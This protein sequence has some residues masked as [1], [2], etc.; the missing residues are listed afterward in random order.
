M[1][2]KAHWV[3]LAGI[4]FICLKY[5]SAQNACNSSPC[6]NGATCVESVL[7]PGYVCLCNGQFNGQQCEQSAFSTRC[8]SDSYT[9]SGT[10]TSPNY[11]SNYTQRLIC[12]YNIRVAN[13]SFLT[14]TFSHLEIERYKDY[15]EIAP[16]PFFIETRETDTNVPVNL[17][18]DGYYVPP[19]L[20]FT[21]ETNQVVILF[22]SD[23][24]VNLKGWSLSYES[25][26]SPCATN[27]CENGGSCLHLPPNGYQCFCSN[28]WQGVNCSIAIDPCVPNPCLNEATCDAISLTEYSCTCVLGW[29]GDLCDRGLV[30]ITDTDLVILSG[31]PVTEGTSQPL[32]TVNINLTPA[33]SSFQLTGTD[34]WRFEFYYSN[35]NDGSGSIIGSGSALLTPLQASTAWIPPNVASFNSV[36]V[37]TSLGVITCSEYRYLCV[38]VRK[39]TASS[40]DYDLVGFPDL[41]ALNHCADVGCR[42]VEITG[43]HLSLLTSEL[44]EGVSSQP[45]QFNLE[46]ESVAEA[47]S[48]RGSNLWKFTMFGS[49]SSNGFGSPRISS[50]TA[51]QTPGHRNT[52]VNAGILSVFNNLQGTF[53]LNQIICPQVPYFCVQVEKGDTAFPDFTFTGIPDESILTACVPVPCIGV[54]ITRTYFSIDAGGVFIERRLSHS[55]DFSSFFT[56]SLT[57]GSVSGNRLWEVQ[58]FASSS[59]DGSGQ[60]YSVSNVPLTEQQASVGNIAGSS[61]SLQQLTA[62][63]N[64]GG[65]K[66]DQL[67]YMCVTLDKGS[68]ASPNFT[69]DPLPNSEVLTSCTAIECNGVIVTTIIPRIIRGIPIQYGYSS[70]NFTCELTVNAKSD[71]ASIAGSGLWN[72]V[73]YVNNQE[74]GRGVRAAEQ[75]ISLTSAHTTT[76]LAAG[77]Q[78]FFSQLE[79]NFDLSGVSSCDDVMFLCFELQKA[80]SSIPDFTLEGS[81][82]TCLSIN[83]QEYNACDSNPC[84]NGGI[85]FKVG[86]AFTCT[87]AAGWTGPV[88]T[89]IIDNCNPNPCVNGGTCV[90]Q[91]ASYSC[92]CLFGWRGPNCGETDTGVEISGTTVL[93]ESGYLRQSSATNTF[94]LDV[95]L[96]AT[97]TSALASGSGLWKGRA[98]GSSSSSGSGVRYA[99]QDIT[100]DS[101]QAETSIVPNTVR[102]INNVMVDF[103]FSN[104]VCIE[105]QYLCVEIQKGDNP[106]PDFILTGVPSSDALVGCVEVTCLGVEITSIFSGLPR[107]F[108]V[109]ERT[110]SQP[111]NF[112]LNIV[113]DRA[114][115]SVTGLGLWKLFGYFTSSDNSGVPQVQQIQLDAIQAATGITAGEV[116]TIQNIAASLSLDGVCADVGYFC[117]ALARGDAPSVDFKLEETSQLSTCIEVTCR[118]VGVTG[119]SYTSTSGLL[120]E[121]SANHPFTFDLL[122]TSDPQGASVQGSNLWNVELFSSF[123][124]FGTKNNVI[125]QV[126]PLT[127]E[128]S[129]TGLL[130]GVPVTL[131]NVM[132]SLD[133][134]TVTCAD[135]PFLCTRLSRSVS[136][137]TNF[138]LESYPDGDRLTNCKTVGCEEPNTAPYFLFGGDFNNVVIPEDS[139]PGTVIYTLR[140]GDNEGDILTYGLVGDLANQLFQVNSVT[141]EVTLRTNLDSENVNIYNISVS[142]SDGRETVIE[143]STVFVGDVN[144]NAPVFIGTPYTA[145]V[146]ESQAPN[147][148]IFEVEAIDLDSGQNG[149][150]TYQLA[151]AS[152]L[153]EV[154]PSSGEIILIGTLNFEESASYQLR[155]RAYDGGVPRM[156]SE[157]EVII[158]VGDV[159][160]SDPVFVNLPYS[161]TVDEETT[162]GSV[163]QVV[164]A[165]DPDVDN[166]NVIQYSIISGNEQGFFSINSSTGVLTLANMIDLESGAPS[167]FTVVVRATEI[168]PTGGAS[169]ITEFTIRVADV[170]DN[171]P[172]FNA[173]I[174]VETISELSPVN[175]PLNLGISINDTDTGINSAYLISLRGTNRNLFSVAPT[176]GIGLSTPVV[177]LA[178]TL[179]YE[180]S[181]SYTVEIYATDANDPTRE[182][183]STI[184]VNLMNENDNSPFF[185]PQ[186]YLVNILENV[187]VG[188]MVL[189]VTATDNDG[190]LV[191][192]EISNNPSFTIDAVSGNITT[193]QELN[194]EDS[195]QHIFTVLASDNRNPPRTATV[196][197]IVNVENVNDNAPQFPRD[198]YDLNTFE[199]EN[200]GPGNPLWTLEATDS[201]MD[202]TNLPVYS[203]LVTSPNGDTMK[204]S[205]YM[206]LRI[207]TLSGVGYIYTTSPIDYDVLDGSILVTVI[208]EDSD[209]LSDT[210]TLNINVLDT[211]DNAPVFNQSSYSFT[212]PENIPPGQSIFQVVATDGDRSPQYGTPS[213][214]YYINPPSSTFSIFQSTG[215]IFTVRS[216][217][218]EAGDTSY[219]LQVIAIDSFQP[220]EM[221]G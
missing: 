187:T 128:Q 150:V 215:Q 72:I 81:T 199:N 141:G 75:Q 33:A 21:L 36:A 77:G 165:E 193:T 217:D 209:G 79:F 84:S 109:V 203:F 15:I 69:L 60:R 221:T 94:L 147:S 212:I 6:R 160:D 30:I 115:G 144:D 83:C 162:V 180:T 189:R 112:A 19:P 140:G 39:G 48:V 214:R 43:V 197:V 87:C 44:L 139:Q 183:S 86:E 26:L 103:D 7:E 11:P 37:S 105:G 118:G 146:E 143:Y 76:S 173:P 204:V 205:E 200:Y 149:A 152:E 85:C 35:Q 201:D 16:D 170:N 168:G 42:G 182:T 206:G 96:Q 130:A 207:E 121:G 65:T 116:A 125:D 50:T 191:T 185:S 135:I 219:E 92:L 117:M 47:G 132:A 161:P 5:S 10:V 41:T 208:A 127:S 90:N 174:Y 31:D 59:S 113:S 106:A 110:S 136:A 97:A 100:F 178:S 29:T 24:N 172:V 67:R 25:T 98:F 28:E 166:P 114:A 34:L 184:I 131:Q 124:Q 198:R 66:C 78:A 220:N 190:D 148:V 8:G 52:P 89:Q 164:S 99:E 45:I 27:P 22:T 82:T 73:A 167:A 120:K 68:N 186:S 133:L 74:D 195:T 171:L 2:Q 138:T 194:Y 108:E 163:V 95:F 1:Y 61:S 20:P 38:N 216:L 107:G 145:T 18:Y 46:L 12:F 181:S 122:I 210:A 14:F 49:A 119:T 62:T 188:A 202:P 51:T 53:N 4:I 9:P 91:V 40:V 58:S 151:E 101:V 71:G 211:N 196:Q 80:D 102:L 179:D 155:V 218:Y 169:A 32:F 154:S 63:F 56:T 175:T 13:A 111:I 129:G 159:Q 213:L 70:N 17:T 3:T 153:F 158:T 123:D 142:V 126:V 157:E 134:S 192:Y 93:L 104:R 156:E 176:S 23:K 55:V 54:Q 177:S 137:S 57:G 64:L 88:C